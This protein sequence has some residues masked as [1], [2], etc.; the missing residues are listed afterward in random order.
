MSKA[1]RL[2]KTLHDFVHITIHWG[3][4]CGLVERTE[5][6]VPINK[7]EEKETAVYRYYV[8]LRGYKPFALL[9]C[10]ET[11]QWLDNDKIHLSIS[12]HVIYYTKKFIEEFEIKNEL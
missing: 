9:K 10:I 8:Q 6:N 5:I 1:C 4:F 11:H 3:E 12:N 2:M 7:E